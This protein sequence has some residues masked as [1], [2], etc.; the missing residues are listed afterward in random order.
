MVAGRLA[1]APPSGLSHSDLDRARVR[2]GGGEDQQGSDDRHVRG[3]VAPLCW[4]LSGPNLR[5]EINPRHLTA[6]YPSVPYLTSSY[7]QCHT[8]V[9]PYYSRTKLLR[10]RCPPD[11]GGLGGHL[12]T[13]DTHV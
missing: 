9:P 7:S 4:N 13:Y 1:E 6:S 3:R 2:M 8:Y 11:S 10:G 5:P 12:I